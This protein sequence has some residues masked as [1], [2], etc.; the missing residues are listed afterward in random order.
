MLLLVACF[1]MTVAHGPL[2]AFFSIDLAAHGYSKTAIGMLWALGVV[3][4]IIVFWL[5]PRWAGRLSMERVL[6]ASFAAAVIRFLMIGWLID[7]VTAIIVAQVLHAATFGSYH[8][9]A[10]ALIHRTFDRGRE[11]RGQ[12]LYSSVSY[13]AGGMVGAAGGGWA[14]D[15]VGPAATMSAASAAALLGLLALSMRRKMPATAVHAGPSG[16]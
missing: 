8:V 5:M 4:E 7:S 15:A 3:V 10:L 2:Y 9:A 13:G 16:R 14:W 11:T 12:A 1:L 6:L